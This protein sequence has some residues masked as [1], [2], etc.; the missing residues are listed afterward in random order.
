[1]TLH[2]ELDPIGDQSDGRLWEALL[3]QAQANLETAHAIRLQVQRK[4]SKESAA[5]M[6]PDRLESWYVAQCDAEAGAVIAEQ[7]VH[8]AEGLRHDD[9]PNAG[10][11]QE[12]R[13]AGGIGASPDNAEALYA[14]VAKPIVGTKRREPSV[15]ELPTA[16]RADALVAGGDMSLTDGKAESDEASRSPP[17]DDRKQSE[18]LIRTLEVNGIVADVNGGWK[19]REEH[20]ANEGQCRALLR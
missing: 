12:L 1:M 14:V 20:T 5:V 11:E 17:G 9:Q 18:G 16:Q 8:Q 10:S 15:L 6:E 4:L 19:C 3:K 2:Q 7:I 13:N